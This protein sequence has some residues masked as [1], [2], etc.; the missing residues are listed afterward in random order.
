V[1]PPTC[2]TQT[3]PAPVRLT[4]ASGG[5]LRARSGQ[6]AFVREDRGLG[7]VTQVELHQDPL[8]VGLHG[9]FLDHEGRGVL[10]VRAPAGDQ[11]E[12]LALAGREPVEERGSPRA[13]RRSC[14]IPSSTSRASSEGT[15]PSP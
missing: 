4:T 6:S 13:K 1:V 11:P 15:P 5:R 10:G 3:D 12:Y 7:S 2:Q 9:G 14:S 8:D